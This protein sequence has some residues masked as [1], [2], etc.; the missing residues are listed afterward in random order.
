MQ[1]PFTQVPDRFPWENAGASIAVADVDADGR[2]DVV[3]LM[4]D[5]PPGRNA[6]FYR[7][8][9]ALDE[10]GALTGGWTDLESVPDWFSDEN[11]GA[12]VAAADGNGNGA[13]DLV[14]F[15]LTPRTGPTWAGSGSA[16]RWTRRPV[17]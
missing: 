15:L 3:L 8:G 6:A 10:S 14:V 13:L 11:Q 2:P 7:V 1:T 5:A 17:R 4:V 16:G 12:G 9:R